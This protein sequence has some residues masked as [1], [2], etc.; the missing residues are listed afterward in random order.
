M[1]GLFFGIAI[2]INY[3]SRNSPATDPEHDR[4]FVYYKNLS[5]SLLNDVKRL[6]QENTELWRKRNED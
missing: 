6:R 4:D 2:C 1:I 5:E 3:K